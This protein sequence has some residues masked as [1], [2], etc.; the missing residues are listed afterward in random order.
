MRSKVALIT[1]ASSGIGA[2]TAERL[3]KADYKVF[4][5]SRRAAPAGK[6]PFEM[7]VL[8]SGCPDSQRDEANLD[9]FVERG[10]DATQHRQGVA[11]IVVVFE[12]RDDRGRR[13]NAVGELLLGELCLGSQLVHLTGH[14]GAGTGFLE[15]RQPL[16]L[17][18]EESTVDVLESGGS[19]FFLAMGLVLRWNE[20]MS[21]RVGVELSLP[22]GGFLDVLWRDRCLLFHYAVRS[23]RGRAPMKEVQHSI[24]HA[25]M[26]GTQLVDAVGEVVGLRTPQ[27]VAKFFGRSRRTRHFARAAEGSA[28]NQSTKGIVPS[29]SRKKMTSTFGNQR[30]RS[31]F[32]KLRSLCKQFAIS[33]GARRR[34]TTYSEPKHSP[35]S[36][37]GLLNKALRQLHP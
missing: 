26:L 28:A 7:P 6:R 9:S 31:S 34:C 21:P 8:F 19:L 36:E 14:L 17:S 16:W 5:T 3:A 10:G 4:G 33:K 20:R 29:S 27:L 25:G 15:L 24:I 12:S 32:A 30:P 37:A 11:I 1:G 18:S 23:N 22:T 35:R 13:T 2:A